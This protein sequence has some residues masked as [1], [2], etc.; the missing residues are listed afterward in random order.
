MLKHKS[1][2]TGERFCCIPIH[3]GHGHQ[4]VVWG[5]PGKALHPFHLNLP[6]GF[7]WLFTESHSELKACLNSLEHL[8]P[9]FCSLWLFAGNRKQGHLN[10]CFLLPAVS[11]REHKAAMIY[12]AQGHLNPA[13]CSHKKPQRAERRVYFK[14][15]AVSGGTL[16][17]SAISCKEQ[18]FTNHHKLHQTSW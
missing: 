1:I 18:K 17:C 4:K 16:S 8:S 15:A 6:L 10:P 12:M 13:F 5:V 9:V 11:Y 3:F 2:F 14:Q 7:L